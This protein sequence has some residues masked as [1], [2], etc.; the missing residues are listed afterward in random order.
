MEYELQ[1]AADNSD[2]LATVSP[3]QQEA[4]EATGAPKSVIVELAPTLY[5]QLSVPH[6][7]MSNTFKSKCKCK[8]E[9]GKVFQIQNSFT[10]KKE[11]GGGGGDSVKSR[12]WNVLSDHASI[13]SAALPVFPKV[14]EHSLHRCSP[15]VKRH[16]RNK[17]DH[18]PPLQRP[19]ETHA[20]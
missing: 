5:L 2:L 11:R 18:G 19:Q 1:A 14:P 17:G 3:C 10:T 8:L 4:R 13:F 9:P 20:L 16:L 12:S 6:K 7:K 15:T